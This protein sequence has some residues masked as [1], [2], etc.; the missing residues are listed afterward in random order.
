MEPQDPVQQWEVVAEVHG[1][2]NGGDGTHASRGNVV[3]NRMLVSRSSRV[4]LVIQIL[5]FSLNNFYLDILNV[6]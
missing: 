6:K 2:S 3:L 4:T 1:A 5:I